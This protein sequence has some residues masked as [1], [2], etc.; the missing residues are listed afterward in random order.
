MGKPS[1]VGQP[2]RPTQPFILTGSINELWSDG[3]YHY[4]VAPSGE[5]LRVKAGEVCLQC[6][7][8]VIHTWALQRWVPYYGALYK[9]QSLT[10]FLLQ[11]QNS[12]LPQTLLDLPA[13]DIRARYK[14]CKV[15]YCIRFWVMLQ[16][17]VWKM[18]LLTLWPL[19]LTFQPPNHV[20]SRISQGHF[21]YQVWT[22][23]DHSFS[24]YAVDKQTDRQTNR[25]A[26]TF[27]PRRVMN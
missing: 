11:T 21:L 19:P 23:W 3:C 16:T 26:R 14:F 27:Y 5:R 17:K 18:H 22:L 10:L 20:T 13:T 6:E 24:S 7:S 25:L 2:S 1:A 12:P 4:L 15:L 8:C 9:C